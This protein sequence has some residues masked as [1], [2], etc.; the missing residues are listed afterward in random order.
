MVR[1]DKQEEEKKPN[2]HLPMLPGASPCCPLGPES[3]RT[4]RG[5]YGEQG[6]GGGLGLVC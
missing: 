1:T 4:E 2:R 3:G 5:G 6:R